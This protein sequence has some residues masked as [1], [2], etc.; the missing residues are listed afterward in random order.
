MRGQAPLLTLRKQRLF[1]CATWRRIWGHYA[2]EHSL[3][4][5]N[6]AERFAVNTVVQG[7]AADL[8]KVAMIR[9]DRRICEEKRPSKMLLQVHDELVFE[10]PRDSIAAEAAMIREE[11]AGALKLTVPIKVDVASGLNWLDMTAVV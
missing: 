4:S 3:Q 8:I 1:A 9:I 6:A 2:D 10:T 11:M 5:V 7:S